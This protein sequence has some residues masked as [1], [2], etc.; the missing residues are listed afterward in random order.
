MHTYSIDRDIRRKVTI[1]IFILSML[2]SLVLKQQFADALSKFAIALKT[3]EGKYFVELVEWF[4]LNPDILGIPFLYA[5]ITWLY[6]K[7]IWKCP[8]C[9]RIHGIPNLNGKWEGG[10]TS[11]FDGKTIPMEMDIR[12]TWSKISF[13]ST[14]TQT[15]SISYSNVAAIYVDGNNGV[16][17]S[18]AFRNNSYSVPNKTQSYDG[19]N[20]LKL[21]EKN[22]IK[23]RYFN[24]RDNPNPTVKGGNKGEFEVKRKKYQCKFNKLFKK[25]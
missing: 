5:T 25:K 2:L 20:I 16:E 24:D 14:F 18:F 7:W 9:L 10:L 3:S 12:Q 1:G 6:E 17:I 15:N 22:K 11:S 21:V 19:Y 4:E 8:F 13:Q 23:A